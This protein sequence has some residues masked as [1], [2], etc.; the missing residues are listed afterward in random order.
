[1]S[2][3]SCYLKLPRG[4]SIQELFWQLKHKSGIDFIYIPVSTKHPKDKWGQPT[5]CLILQASSVISAKTE[6]RMQLCSPQG[7]VQDM[8]AKNGCNSHFR[9]KCTIKHHSGV[10][11]WEAC[12]LQRYTLLWWNKLSAF[13]YL[14]SSRGAKQRLPKFVTGMATVRTV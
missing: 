12:F 4:R 11:L 7:F 1:M 9:H 8:G 2:L 10:L 3:D 13:L 6:G 14:E 5:S